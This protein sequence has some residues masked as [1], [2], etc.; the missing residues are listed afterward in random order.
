MWHRSGKYTELEKRVA[1][2]MRDNGFTLKEIAKI[3]H[4]ADPEAIRQCFYNW[5]KNNKKLQTGACS[6][7]TPDNCALS[8]IHCQLNGD[9]CLCTAEL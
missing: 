9:P 6:I 7:G 4:R 5:E 1:L 3:L 2:S 8:K